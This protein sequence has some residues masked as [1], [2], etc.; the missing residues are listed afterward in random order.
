MRL[1]DGITPGSMPPDSRV[2]EEE[3][4]LIDD[5]QLIDQ[6]EF[7]ESAMRKLL[8]D[9]R[10]PV[11]NV[12]QNLADIRA[13]VAA[14]EKGGQEL[15]AMVGHFGL[16][17]V[18]AYM[19]HVQD[20]AEHS[21]RKVLGALR[22][23]HFEYEMDDGSI[24][25]VTISINE[26]ARSA[27]VDFTGTSTQ[28]ESNFNAPSSVAR[29]AVMYVF[30]T[31]VEVM[32]P[33]NEGCLKPIEIIIPDGCMLKPAY[34]AAVVAGNVETSQ[35]I[36]DALY[37]ALGVMAVAQGTLRSVMKPISIMRPSAAVPAL[38]PTSLSAMQCTHI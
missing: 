24:I 22:N 26:E 15:R 2:I 8:T 28:Q 10:Y 17:V 31:L 30:R 11:R 32:I 35:Y 25:A 14:N 36:T 21:I 38:V 37:G 3:G 34:P 27:V 33:M 13:Q 16:E 1:S 23:G 12:E 19:Q 9:A 5:V 6:G 7:L 4:V 18:Q 20:N 29:A